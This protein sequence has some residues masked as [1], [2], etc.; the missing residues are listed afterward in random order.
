VGRYKW[1][2]R[3]YHYISYDIIHIY[4]H[5]DSGGRG[6]WTFKAAC[7]YIIWRSDK[8]SNWRSFPCRNLSYRRRR[9][10]RIRRF[11]Q[12]ILYTF[13]AT[14]ETDLHRFYTFM[15]KLLRQIKTVRLTRMVSKT[16]II[17]SRKRKPC[18]W[19]VFLET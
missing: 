7:A 8:S 15:Y 13:I 1:R 19:S 9:R 16:V 2:I 10:H 12:I 6:D 18:V 17:I 14:E 3:V 5:N 11:I 4:T